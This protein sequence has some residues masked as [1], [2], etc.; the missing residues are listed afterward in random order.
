MP[1]FCG[2]KSFSV[3]QALHSNLSTGA[4]VKVGGICGQ[5]EHVYNGKLLVNQLIE[6]RNSWES[7]WQKLRLLLQLMGYVQTRHNQ[8]HI[9]DPNLCN[10]YFPPVNLSVMCQG[11]PREH[12]VGQ[13]QKQNQLQQYKVVVV[14]R[15]LQIMCVCKTLITGTWPR[16]MTEGQRVNMPYK[17]LSI[18]HPSFMAR[19][20]PVLLRPAPREHQPHIPIS[21][22]PHSQEAEFFL[23]GICKSAAI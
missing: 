7:S 16:F 8:F 3:F 19:K 18:T 12:Q 13:I 4:N 6:M 1:Y 5:Q 2:Q 10:Q 11:L 21:S 20:Q 23:Q 15:G 22:H 9:L 17:I 14:G